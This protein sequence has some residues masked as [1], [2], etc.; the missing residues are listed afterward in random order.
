[1][2][3]SRMEQLAG[4][5]VIV[6]AGYGK[7][8]EEL[9]AM[10]P[11]YSTLV[12]NTIRFPDFEDHEL[13]QI[14]IERFKSRFGKQLEIE[15]GQHGVSMRVVA[16]RIGRGRG[17]SGFANA[18]E[19]HSIFTRILIRQANRLFREMKSGLPTNDRRLTREDLIGPPPSS[20]F[21]DT[22][23][24]Q[25]LQ[26]M[27]GLQSVKDTVRALIHRLQINYDRELA[28]LPLVQCSLNKLFLGNPG[29]GKTTVAK[30]Y[31]QIL[32][33]IGLLSKGGVVLKNPSDFIGSALGHS[34]EN[35]KAI[36]NAALGKVLIIDEAY[37]LSGTSSSDGQL[38]STD[39]YRMAVIDTLV[40]EVQS[41]TT[42]DRAVLLLGYRK[43]MEAMLDEVNPALARRFP[44][45][46]AFVFEDYSTDEMSQ[47]LDRK[48]QEQGFKAGNATRKVMLEIL[49]RGRCRPGF[50]NAGEIDILLDRA[51]LQQHERLAKFPD[52]AG[53]DILEPSDIDKDFDRADRETESIRSL[54][55][56]FFD[57]DTVIK[58]LETYRHLV[59]NLRA[60]DKDPREAIPFNFIFCGPPGKRRRHYRFPKATSLIC[61]RHR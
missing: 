18:R 48:L 47:I 9:T 20:V 14:L 21:N 51:K 37:G 46:S 32:T 7:Q 33:E 3:F 5:A 1:M 2:L 23:A 13:H 17:I 8:M 52:A 4:K 61:S 54:F 6:F 30:L 15:D 40:A 31:G 58:Q 60:L 42:E 57:F 19:V 39:P 59:R 41:T 12:P 43:R 34:E 49:N 16:R 22:K 44:V 10:H 45:T 25:Q 29:T 55:R 56:E 36:L 27:I 53:A 24:W 50:G 38:Q 26:S 35:T 28:E 11:L